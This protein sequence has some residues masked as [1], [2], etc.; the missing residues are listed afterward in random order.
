VTTQVIFLNNGD[1][2]VRSWEVKEYNEFF[3]PLAFL[4]YS[5]SVYGIITSSAPLSD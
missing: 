2:F 1:S 5:V 4:A 3:I